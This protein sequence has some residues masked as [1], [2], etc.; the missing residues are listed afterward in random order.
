VAVP[1]K[2]NIMKLSGK[3]AEIMNNQIIIRTIQS[4]NYSLSFLKKAY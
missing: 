2:F 3:M 1:G 4:S